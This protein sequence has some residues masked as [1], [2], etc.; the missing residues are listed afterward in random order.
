MGCVK[1]RPLEP[2]CLLGN[3][4]E[5][6]KD[7]GSQPRSV[8]FKVAA[9]AALRRHTCIEISLQ[10]VVRFL[11]VAVNI[12]KGYKIERAQTLVA[13]LGGN[14]DRFTRGL[15]RIIQPSGRAVPAGQNIGEPGALAARIAIFSAAFGD[16]PDQLV[17][18]YVRGP[19]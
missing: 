13:E 19:L 18:L 11:A 8:C 17:G 7:A 12:A 10:G 6:V 5:V 1:T 16:R 2:C 14:R 15:E 4:L 9:T 3:G